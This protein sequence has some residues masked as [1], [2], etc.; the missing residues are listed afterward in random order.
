M[1]LSLIRN[2]HNTPATSAL[3]SCISP[4]IA[5]CISTFPF[6]RAVTPSTHIP[7]LIGPQIGVYHFHSYSHHQT[8]SIKE[9]VPVQLAYDVVEP[10]NPF[11]EAV[12]QSLVI[13]HGLFGSKQ[14][15][16]SL[17]KAFAVKLGMPVYTLDLRNHGQSPHASPHT[18]S[19][20]AADIHQ[21]FISH[22]LTSGVNLLGHSMGGKAVMALAL[23]GDLNGPLR[24]LISVDMSPAK[25]KIS[26]EFASYTNAMMDI[27]TARVKTKQEADVIL[28]KT[29]P[30]LATRQFLL[31]NTRLSKSPSPHLTFRIPLSL[32]S[33][34]IP[35]IGDF[36]YSPPPPVSS[37]SPQWD[38]PVLLIK[39]EQ[40]KYLNKRNIPVT[41]SFF[42]Q[43]KLEVLD[44]GHWVHAEKP[45][46]TV[47]LVR[48]FIQGVVQ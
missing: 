8:S 20:M 28:Q 9:Q 16:R 44:A 47:E 7:R 40:S 6:G 14:N 27:E 22:K 30:I 17:A 5:R 21:F 33:A 2:I 18:Y 11:P 41:S 3:T 38:G 32:L 46:E 31:T 1:R 35:H 37:N 19:A 25:G 13:C 42:P 34:A 29:E 48:S 24:S 43:M 4:S 12:G 10:S 39:G 23:N 26:P 15:W 36:P 45:V